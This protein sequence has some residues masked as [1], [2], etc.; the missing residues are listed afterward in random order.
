MAR[1][2]EL[3]RIVEVNEKKLADEKSH[4]YNL[5]L[6]LEE[7]KLKADNLQKELQEAMSYPKSDLS[8]QLDE[9][10]KNLEA[11]KGKVVA[12]KKRADLENCEKEEQKKAAESNMQKAI[13]ER[14]RAEMLLQDLQSSAQRIENL[15][16]EVTK[17]NCLLEA[18]R[19]VADKEK[20]RADAL[21]LKLEEQQRIAL[22]MEKSLQEKLSEILE[23]EKK[24]VEFE[25]KHADIEMSAK[26]EQIKVSEANG[27]KA[28][29]EKLR[30]NKLEQDLQSA[31]QRIHSL[32]V[33]L[34][35][36][37]GMLE[38][39]KLLAKERNHTDALNLKLEEQ[40]RFA[41]EVEKSRKLSIKLEAEKKKVAHE[42]KRA[43]LEMSAKEVQKKV[44][45]ANIKKAIEEKLRADKLEQDLQ[46]GRQ[47]TESLEVELNK[48]NRMLE[49]ERLLLAKERNHA[50]ALKSKLEEQSRIAIEN[51]KRAMEEESRS[52]NMVQELENVRNKLKDV[53]N[54][55]YE[56]K[57][58]RGLAGVSI[59]PDEQFAKVSLLQEQ[60]KFE[61]KRVKHYKEV[62][63]FEK[64][65][66]TAS[67]QELHNVKHDFQC[68]L[69]QMDV[70]SVTFG[71]R[72]HLN[73]K[74]RLNVQSLEFH[75]RMPSRSP[76]QL[77]FCCDAE[78]R[79]SSLSS[80][81]TSCHVKPNIGL[82]DAGQPM[83][84]PSASFSDEQL[85]GS[86][87]R[88]AGSL[89]GMEAKDPDRRAIMARR[90][91]SE[92]VGTVAEKST[93][94]VE[95]G[96]GHVTKR[97]KIVDESESIRCSLPQGKT[98]NQKAATN[99]FDLPN[100]V[101]KPMTKQMEKVNLPVTSNDGNPLGNFDLSGKKRKPPHEAQV[102]LQ[103]V[104]DSAMQMEKLTFPTPATTN[105]RENSQP[106]QVIRSDLVVFSQDDL[107]RFEEEVNGDYMRLLDLDDAAAE[108]RFKMALESPLSPLPDIDLREFEE[109]VESLMLGMPVCARNNDTATSGEYDK[110]PNF[111]VVFSD[112]GDVGS[113][114]RIFC[115]TRT[116][117][118][119]LCSPL[120]TPW[121][122]ENIL[123]PLVSELHLVPREKVCVF[124]S[125]IL[126]NFAAAFCTKSTKPTEFQSQELLDTFSTHLQSVLSNLEIRHLFAKVC[127]LPDLLG[128]AEDF[129][130]HRKILL[131]SCLTAPLNSDDSEIEILHQGE[132]NF[133]HHNLASA[134]MVIAG[135]IVMASIS[136]AAG[137]IDSLCELS[138]RII[139]MSRVDCSLTL[140]IL[141]TFAYV[142]GDEYFTNSNYY[143]AMKAVK[144]MV[145]SVESSLAK[146]DDIQPGDG[147]W[148]QFF[149][150]SR[151]RFT[152]SS[153]CLDDVLSKLLEEVQGCTQSCPQS[154]TYGSPF[155]VAAV[156]ALE[157]LAVNMSWDWVCNKVVSK[158][159]ETLESC[160]PESVLSTTVVT[161]L[162]DIG[163]RGVEAVGYS[164]PGVKSITDQL[165][166]NLLRTSTMNL[167]TIPMAIVHALIKL[168]PNSND[169]VLKNNEDRPVKGA[170][171]ASCTAASDIM[172]TMLSSL[173]PEH[174]STMRPILNRVISGIIA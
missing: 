15:Q 13:E 41:V 19:L 83:E 113:I 68:L 101:V 90:I 161:L 38:A 70:L 72:N 57:Q 110:I 27:K 100:V 165:S 99:L 29:E 173:S 120:Q 147:T 144:C 11:E 42:K 164:D 24:K 5:S 74:R 118:S 139:R 116:C 107:I 39:E 79:L 153:L 30:G 31:R 124:F 32:E 65:R 94:P 106:E 64:D 117:I 1:V 136:V 40:K 9:L 66:K 157:L 122:V 134:N 171:P 52:I 60:L 105:N 96:A 145:A 58:S 4:A 80:R 53:E 78:V 69:Q 61:K 115:A 14:Q 140:S 172:T 154:D 111:C 159:F 47:K 62:A 102:V 142:C 86:Q 93:D 125:L 49:A 28:M 8:S 55:L 148:H 21:N 130:L 150:F 127:S 174:T 131:K 37:N 146:N 51:E 20:K 36:V 151:C 92:R 46:Y 25:K 109:E 10:I 103:Q 128:L 23:A 63:K 91:D 84:S 26:E 152:G 16:Q 45:D 121:L 119:H 34:K 112:M 22:E 59:A 123:Q 135:S 137:L 2:N 77:D 108:K 133:L 85:L 73:K 141:H 87:E 43:D 169:F 156:S 143:L 50:D 3:T 160:D 158:L 48:V 138:L 97:R 95:L 89:T 155:L 168:Y 149:P 54:Q 33:E 163:K 7:Q 18:E 104:G 166:A 167:N 71:A 12:E 81:D 56:V 132:S 98:I 88:A 76:P 35:K 82:V 170:H 67:Q 114:T 75:G 44:S 129:L 162:G 126:I 6:M 17:V